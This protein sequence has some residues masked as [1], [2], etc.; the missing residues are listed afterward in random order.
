MVLV[1]LQLVVG[2]AGR[3]L[4]LVVVHLH[5]ARLEVVAHWL[6]DNLEI[7]EEHRLQVDSLAEHNLV[8]L[9]TRLVLVEELLL[10]LEADNQ[11]LGEMRTEPAAGI[12][13]HQDIRSLYVPEDI[14]LVA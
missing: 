7:G 11:L 1:M 12:L 10:V 9:G 13:L 6:V 5:Q 4:Q 2:L 8:L 3:D 14:P